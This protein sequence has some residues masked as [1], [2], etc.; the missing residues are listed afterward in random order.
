[1]KKGIKL[2]VG[3]LV[4][5]IQMPMWWFIMYSVL[6]ASGADRLL[7]FI[8]YCYIPLSFFSSTISVIVDK[9]MED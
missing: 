9:A 4:I 3:L 2:A 5:F 1:V 7:W 6:K 8:F